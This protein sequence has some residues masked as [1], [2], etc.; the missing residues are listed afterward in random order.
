[1]M[2]TG[3]IHV[4]CK[5]AEINIFEKVSSGDLQSASK[6]INQFAKVSYL[7]LRKRVGSDL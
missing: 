4:L 2:F 7:S 5:G 6:H 1:M 3:E